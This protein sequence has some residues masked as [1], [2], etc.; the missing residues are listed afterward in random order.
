M[1][2]LAAAGIDVDDV[3][4]YLERDG[5]AKFEKRAGS[6]LALPSHPS[7]NTSTANPPAA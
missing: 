1:G 6:S 4:A 3:T 7:W 5:L 2:Q